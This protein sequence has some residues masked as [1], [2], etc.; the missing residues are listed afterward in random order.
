MSK[1][2]VPEGFVAESE[3]PSG[4]VPDTPTGLPSLNESTGPSVSDRIKT[5]ASEL[6]TPTLKYGGAAI[7]GIGGE[8]IAAS[9][10]NPV[11]MAV[12]PFLGAGGGYAAGSSLAESL[13]QLIGLKPTGKF[14]SL[15]TKEQAKEEAR[16]TVENVRTG[17]EMEGVGRTVLGPATEGVFK[18]LTGSAGAIIDRGPE[19]I[20]R[21]TDAAQKIGVNL[22][23]AEIIGSK[24]LSA[25]ESVLDNLPW[26]SG[27]VQK[28]RLGQLE[29]LN[30]Y[31]DKLISENGS[32]Q[33]IE[34][35]GIKIKNIA[36]QFM[37]K[38]TSANKGAMTAMKTRLL[39]KIGSNTSYED[40][41]I[42]AKEA[43]QRHQQQVSEQVSD[44]YKA[45]ADKIPEGTI[46]PNS[47]RQAAQRILEEQNRL[48]PSTRNPDL[49]SAANFLVQ[50]TEQGVPL[51]KTYQ[52]LVDNVKSFNQKKFGQ[53]NTAGGGYQIS[54]AGRQWDQLIDGMREDMTSLA[55]S[56][57]DT[58]LAQ[59][60]NIANQLY[61][62]KL[63]L[64]E[65]P[66]FKT[67]NNKYPGAVAK[68]VL[69]SGNTEL[70]SRYK[71]LVGD[72]LFNKTK[73]RLT[74]DVV[75]LNTE[76]I[77]S[78]DQ[79]RKNILKL[80]ESAKSIYTDT[81]LGYFKKLADAVD[82]R[83]GHI[84][85]LVGNPILKTILK[86]GDA[87]PSG[88]AGAIVKPNNRQN[89]IMI[90]RTFGSNAKKKVADAFLPQLLSTNQHG[91]FAP[92]TFSK[93]YDTFG[94]NTLEEWYGKDFTDTLQSLAE[95]GR[96]MGG[97]E[98]LAGNP[99]GTGRFLIGFYEG[100]RLL[101]KGIDLVSSGG[102]QP[103]V[104]SLGR[105]G[106]MILGS[107]QLAKLYTSPLGRKL[108][109]EGLIT[110]TTARQ[111]G[112]LTS[113]ILTTLGAEQLNKNE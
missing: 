12:A 94:R 98:K 99:S 95:V 9:T 81:E 33:D 73:D 77:V 103:A 108:F 57:G 66:A 7:G 23:P 6:Y 69:Q 58:E 65:D 85:E 68:T 71:A 8:A 40:L 56:T 100:S 17:A 22:T 43:V 37:Q 64:F 93:V 18:T 88:I 19:V 35:L 61:K 107:R 84:D 26:T 110:P 29:K 102:A 41:D 44:A 90:E 25:L 113:R 106:A 50:N 5:T 97:A 36:D 30:T 79:I 20:R 24:S 91:D 96:R 112:Q 72:D 42:S 78:G 45:V 34:E 14:F 59:S 3:V 101:N 21:V 67:I 54:N 28:Y 83:S 76:D 86:K 11:A 46:V 87:A 63:A 82:T 60:Q 62:K 75:G 109:V 47:A 55:N 74:N 92:Q 80:G 53:V 16:K 104:L 89:A 32:V 51:Q 27:I 15:P 2:E 70:I 4:F 10:L 38:T 39:Q 49:V 31:R 1:N 105:D 111:A 52:E 13:D 48:A